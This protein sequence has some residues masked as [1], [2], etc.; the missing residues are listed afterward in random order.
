MVGTPTQ[1]A[2]GVISVIAVLLIL[3]IGIIASIYLHTR[4]VRESERRFRLLFDRVFD[5][6]IL[7]DSSSKI[8][9]INGSACR[10]LGFAGKDLQGT[11][12]KALQPEGEVLKLTEAIATLSRQES[13]FLGETI[14][15]DHSGN[16][17]DVEGALAA[18]EF[19]DE[20]LIIA[21][22]RDI[23]DRK[24]ADKALRTE[25]QALADK[26]I[27]LREVLE[28]IEEEKSEI[29]K[30]VSD[31]VE[32]AILPVLK[33]MMVSKDSVREVY[34]NMLVTELNRLIFAGGGLPS[35]AYKLSPREIEICKLLIGGASTKEIAEA[36]HISAATV[37]KHRERIR[38][39]LDIA[40]KHINL[41]SYL[42]GLS[43]NT[44]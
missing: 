27:A 17:L 14:L 23:T 24:I 10:R 8:I 15:L 33:K 9:D 25:R 22:F 21:S 38:S 5:L 36:L 26:C 11:F 39:R 34:Y 6:L 18:F 28:H 3:S 31:K 44:A 16:Q 29:K 37:N 1:F 13:E 12:L 35:L 4:R 2:W 7:M 40:N 32:Q 30:T 43:N 20:K 41:T 19:A 42:Q